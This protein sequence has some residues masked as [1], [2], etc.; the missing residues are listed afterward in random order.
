[1]TI[2]KLQASERVCNATANAFS[3][4]KVVRLVNKG[5]AVGL[6]TLKDVVKELELTINATANT[7][8]LLTL[9]AGNTEGLRV[10]LF[11]YH[12]SN[13]AV[14]NTDTLVVIDSIVNSTAVT[15]NLDIII[16]TGV[17]NVFAVDNVKT[18]SVP[19]NTTLIIEKGNTDLLSSNNNADMLG[20]SVSVRG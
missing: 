7:T 14:V 16:A 6:V 13:V 12:S 4:A 8:T 5:T 17:C 11:L 18:V 19:P 15:T 3:N 2:V 1:M 10:G 9:S 20:A